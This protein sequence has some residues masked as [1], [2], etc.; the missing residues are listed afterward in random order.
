MDLTN[1]I[2]DYSKDHGLIELPICIV[3]AQSKQ[4]SR[5]RLN[6][7]KENIQEALKYLRL[8]LEYHFR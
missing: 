6:S 2:L 8:D 1:E 3:G 7:S 5:L 4:I